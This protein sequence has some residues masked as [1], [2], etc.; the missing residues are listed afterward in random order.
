[1]GFPF[2][3]ITSS[4]WREAFMSDVLR[5]FDVL[6][7]PVMLSPHMDLTAN[8]IALCWIAPVRD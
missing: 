2:E 7:A 4:L 6:D 8:T 1:L 3:T 5:L